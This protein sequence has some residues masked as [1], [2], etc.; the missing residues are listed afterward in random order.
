MKKSN[1]LF[2]TSSDSEKLNLFIKISQIK[3]REMAD[4]NRLDTFKEFKYKIDEINLRQ[5]ANLLH[6]SYGSIY[7]TYLGIINDMEVIL[8]KKN[9]SI[10]EIF[11][12]D[13]D[14]Y[15]YYLVENSHPY[16]FIMKTIIHNECTSFEE[17]YTNAKSSKATVLRHLKPI[18]TILKKFNLRLTYEPIRLIGDQKM[19]RLGLTALIWNATRGYNWPFKN[20]KREDALEFTKYAL[21]AFNMPIPDPTTLEFYAT[22]VAVNTNEFNKG[23]MIKTQDLSIMLLRYPYPNIVKNYNEE[24]N[25]K[26]GATP[27]DELLESA[28][29]YLYISCLPTFLPQDDEILDRV[30]K[31]Y[32]EYNPGIYNFVE[33]VIKGFP[34]DLQKSMNFTEDSMKQFKN[35]FVASTVASIA[36]K[37]NYMGMVAFYLNYQL[38]IEQSPNVELKNLATQVVSEVAEKEEYRMY[39]SDIASI[40]DALYDLINRR[41]SLNR[42]EN[43]VQVYVGLERYFLVRSDLMQMLESIP[44]VDIN[45]DIQK[46]DL[47]IVGSEKLAPEGINDAS[48][49]F[50]WIYDGLDGQYGELY[51]L[52]HE[53]WSKQKVSKK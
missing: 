40:S 37:G 4:T 9:P 12:V 13:P 33:D 53:I 17:F 7:N 35:N 1:D 47:V 31:I 46:A 38:S 28:H 25:I 23:N 39:R 29:Y 15:H 45:E 22:F 11:N 10:N 26:T 24:N 43:R 44:Y 49:K 51:S 14:R 21:K 3:I 19:I 50:P 8:D 34:F 2:L 36:F 6:K 41:V 20:V 52:I 27:E 32:K 42:E 48:Y 5:V 30:S 16:Q 18:R